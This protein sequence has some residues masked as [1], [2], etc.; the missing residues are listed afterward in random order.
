MLL[1]GLDVRVLREDQTEVEIMESIE[2]VDTDYRY[3]IEGENRNYDYEQKSLGSMGY[4]QQE[5]DKDSGELVS[6]EEEVEVED[7]IEV[8]E[9]EF[10][11]SIDE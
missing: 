1:I 3:E 10:A 8:E 2:F 7:E 9:V 5:F 6:A 4:Q 11:E